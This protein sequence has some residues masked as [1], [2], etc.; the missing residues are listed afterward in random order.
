MRRR[1]GALS[2]AL[3]GMV[4]LAG[5]GGVGGGGPKKIVFN[6]TIC[7]N[8][9]VV[10]MEVGKTYRLVLDDSKSS[11]GQVQMNMRMDNVPLVIK[12]KVPPNS[13]VGN[14]FSTVV[15][16]ATPGN[17]SRVDVTPRSGGAFSFQC[18]SIL[19]TRVQVFDLT[20]QI[21][22]KN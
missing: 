12:G 5:C 19:G 11:P 20:L 6:E 18:G 22:D 13:V 21:I 15:L 1:W 17:E 9:R 3:A 10:Q 16:S 2:A 8:Q 14:P 4:I 7:S